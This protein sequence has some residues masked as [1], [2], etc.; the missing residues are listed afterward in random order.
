MNNG[1]LFIDKINNVW[2][3]TF[4]PRGEAPQTSCETKYFSTVAAAI[5][6]ASSVGTVVKFNKEITSLTAEMQRKE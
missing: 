2:R 6:T 3:M 1:T 4:T 5:E